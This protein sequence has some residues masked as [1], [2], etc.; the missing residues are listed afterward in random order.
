MVHFVNLEAILS[1]T[2]SQ[3]DSTEWGFPKGRRNINENDFGCALR[4]F[5]EET[6]IPNRYVYVVRNIKPFEEVF[7]GL[8]KIRYRHVYFI[9]TYIATNNEH[10]VGVDPSNTTQTREVRNVEWFDYED[11][12]GNIRPFNVERKELFKRVNTMVSKMVSNASEPFQHEALDKWISH[13]STQWR[14]Q[15]FFVSISNREDHERNE[16]QNKTQETNSREE[17]DQQTQS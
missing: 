8:N 7:T 14:H 1:S 6:G 4:E 9:A 5:R 2:T 16:E 3:Y 15:P 17:E 11:A 13:A 10:D 12:Q